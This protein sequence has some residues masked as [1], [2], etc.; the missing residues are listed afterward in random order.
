MVKIA[1]LGL[2]YSLADFKAE[3]FDMSIGVNDIWRVVKS[4][5]VVCLDYPRVF[6]A[7]RWRYIE[8]CKP[9]AFYSQIA[10]YDI[11]PDFVKVNLASGYP[12][13]ACN[14]NTSYLQKSFCSPFV[15]V[16]IA[17]KYYYADE[18]HLFGVDMT[19]H[20]NLNSEL[21]DKIILHFKNLKIALQEKNC[22]L[23]V[24]GKGI[25]SLL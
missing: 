1:I 19:N 18:V 12:D 9:V 24:H 6:T 17:W 7:D 14:I 2:G 5:V 4:E 21:C 8:G 23:V 15:A 16:Q 3:E 13:H 11:R 20:P 22:R 10:D 25:L